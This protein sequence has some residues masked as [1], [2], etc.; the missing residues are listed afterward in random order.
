MSDER[1]ERGRLVVT[2]VGLL[3]LNAASRALWGVLKSRPETTYAD[4]ADVL[5]IVYV[6]DACRYQSGSW[7]GGRVNKKV[8]ALLKLYD[9]ELCRRVNVVSHSDVERPTPEQQLEHARWMIKAMIEPTDEQRLSGKFDS[10]RSINR[11]LGFIQGTLNANGIYSIKELRDQ[12]RHLYDEGL[13]DCASCGAPI[14]AGVVCSSCNDR[15]R[16]CE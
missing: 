4:A 11:W 14:E 16:L 1:D 13:T 12:S 10:E 5:D 7:R 8:A 9:K 15:R 6:V 3:A 2:G